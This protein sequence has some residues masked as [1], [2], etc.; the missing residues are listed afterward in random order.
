MSEASTLREL[1]RTLSHAG[2]LQ[3]HIDGVQP[4]TLPFFVAMLQQRTGRNVAVVAADSNR[5]AAL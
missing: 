5:A 2:K 1:V 3:V 4:S